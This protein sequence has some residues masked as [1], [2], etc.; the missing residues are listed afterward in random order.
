VFISSSP[1]DFAGYWIRAAIDFF[2]QLLQGKS[3]QRYSLHC[4]ERSISKT[5]A[6]NSEHP[7]IDRVPNARIS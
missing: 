4:P 2:S 3:E 6:T 5:R 1:S 7:M